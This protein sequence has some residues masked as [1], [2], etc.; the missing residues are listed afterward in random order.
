MAVT[1]FWH[2]GHNYAMF[3]THSKRDAEQF[4]SIAAAKA[5]F[6]NRAANNDPYYPCVEDSEAWL[7]LCPAKDAVGQEYPD[8]TLKIGPR[9]GVVMSN[10]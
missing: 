1:M 5:E 10:A 3:D 2:G 8:R 4:N 7:F 6:A 9:G